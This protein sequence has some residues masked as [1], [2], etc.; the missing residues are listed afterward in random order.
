M[1]RF[2]FRLQVVLDRAKDEEDV[3]LKAMAQEQAALARKEQEMAEQATRRRDTLSA[4]T[5][6]QR[7]GC[8]VWELQ[9]YR[10]HLDALATRLAQLDQECAA[11]AQRVE[12]ARARVVEAMRKRQVLEKL[13][14]KQLTAYQRECDR[15]ELRNMEETTLPRLS[16]ERAAEAARR[17]LQ[18]VVEG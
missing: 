17:Q 18:D 16:R 13:R 15:E 9:Q 6:K 8:D 14:E 2:T 4:M 11:Q 1:K 3:L 7:T 10:L 5:E 12:Q